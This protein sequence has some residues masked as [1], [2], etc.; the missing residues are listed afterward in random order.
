[1]EAITLRLR[2]EDVEQLRD[3]LLIAADALEHSDR[4]A[5]LTAHIDADDCTSLI[6]KLACAEDLCMTIPAAKESS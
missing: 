1:M 2:P 5:A 6:Y 4:D 3:A